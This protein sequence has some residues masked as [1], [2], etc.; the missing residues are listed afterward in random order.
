[1][2]G[3]EKVGIGTVMAV[4]DGRF[5]VAISPDAEEGAMIMFSLMMGEG[6]EMMEYMAKADTDVMAGMS[7]RPQ[8]D[9]PDGLL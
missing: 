8:D 1:M 3:D 9:Q 4:M 6:D 2:V 7:R 5:E